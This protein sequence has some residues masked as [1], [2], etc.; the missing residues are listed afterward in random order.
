MATLPD[1]FTQFMQANGLAMDKTGALIPVPRQGPADWARTSGGQV[2]AGG[3]PTFNEAAGGTAVD[4]NGNPMASQPGIDES[5][6][7]GPGKNAIN[8][9]RNDTPPIFRASDVK[10]NEANPG[11][12][13]ESGGRIGATEAGLGVAGDFG[14]NSSGVQFTPSGG[15]MWGNS[16]DPSQGFNFAIRSGK[17]MGNQFSYKLDPTGQYFIPSNQ[18][19]QIS[20]PH[21]Q[22]IGN[23][24]WGPALLLAGGYL[25]GSLAAGAG[26]AEAG[27][28]AA[29]GAG[30]ADAATTAA[31]G[32]GAGLGMDTVG[33]VGGGSVGA[34]EVGA[35]M[36]ATGGFLDGAGAAE[37]VSMGTVAP[38][39]A[40]TGNGLAAAGGG[41]GLFSGGTGGAGAGNG[42]L[43]SQIG[44]AMQTGNWGDLA[45]S[46]ISNPS[47]W[48]SLGQSLLGYLGNNAQQGNAA[49]FAQ[50]NSDALFQNANQIR[51]IAGQVTD[52]TQFRP[53]GY[54]NASGSTTYDPTTNTWKSSLSPESQ[55]QFSL[56]N[57]LAQ[58]A[59]QRYKNLDPNALAADRYAQMQSLVAPGRQAKMDSM[60][61]RLKASGQLGLGVT[62]TTGATSNPLMSSLASSNAAEDTRMAMQAADYGQQAQTTGLGQI[63]G[64]F[65]QQRG[66]TQDA[67]A[68]FNPAFQGTGQQMSNNQMTAGLWS[69]LM[70]TAAGQ[71][72]A[73][74]RPNSVLFNAQ[75]Q[76]S[77]NNYGM[78][79]D[80][81][82][83]IMGSFG[84]GR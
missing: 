81:L 39:G 44:N 43:M 30:G 24:V 61:G 8:Q 10:F 83:N 4:L 37:G 84:G 15:G 68:T 46:I 80:L 79:A 23:D 26:G 42:G 64:L 67:N 28:M 25:G 12:E 9:Y 13:S 20:M 41:G 77:A 75:Q 36:G 66:L 6:L 76:G 65:G 19:Q 71:Q 32:S 50:Q 35:G 17:D 48:G 73:A 11:L 5:R 45:S 18:Y 59:V 62:D 58:G 72:L 57:D 60:L 21:G 14:P 38:G 53:V 2:Y 34:G 74:A 22:T 31:W 3:S 56:W 70:Q 40:S 49:N 55:Q 69:N 27:G 47:V 82:K 29:A 7:W 52:K 16:W 1:W 78:W 51:D 33:A 63:A 54:T